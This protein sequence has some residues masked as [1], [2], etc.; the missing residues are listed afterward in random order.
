MRWEGNSCQGPRGRRTITTD[1]STP[2]CKST[3]VLHNGSRAAVAASGMSPTHRLLAGLLWLAASLGL[4]LPVC[5][6][7]DT[8][9]VR[10]AELRIEEEDCVL[11]AQFDI[12]INPT[13]EE[14]LQKG[15]SMYFR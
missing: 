15:V 14:A 3:D 13:L 4:M 12:T 1:F 8:I 5:A 10:G 9:V 11:N 6:G 2:S 7:A